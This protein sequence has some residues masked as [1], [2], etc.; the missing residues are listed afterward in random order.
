MHRCDLNRIPYSRKRKQG[1]KGFKATLRPVVTGGHREE[2]LICGIQEVER[3]TKGPGTRYDLQRHT[4]V[5]Y[6]LQ[7][8]PTS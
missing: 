8:D 5:T 3:A 1:E 7:L 4:P 2:L 6:F